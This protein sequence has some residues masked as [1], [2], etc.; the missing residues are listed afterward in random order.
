MGK[1]WVS[2]F[3]LFLVATL[4]NVYGVSESAGAQK[5]EKKSL[6]DEYAP[7]LYMH[8]DE[9][10]YPIKTKVMVENSELYEKNSNTL[11]DKHPTLAKLIENYNDDT[12]YLKLKDNWDLGKDQDYWKHFKCVVYGHQ[13]AENDKIVL[14]YWFFYI[15]NDWDNSHDG[16]WE[17]IQ[18]I[19]DKDENPEKITYSI[20]LGGATREWDDVQKLYGNHPAVFITIGAHSSWYKEGDNVWNQIYPIFGCLKCIDKTSS[21]GDVLYPQSVKNLSGDVQKYA[22]ID[23]SDSEDEHSPNNWI[24]WKGYWGKQVGGGSQKPLQLGN[25]VRILSSFVASSGPESPPFIDYFKVGNGKSSNGR[26]FKPLAWA[27]NP[28]PSNYTIC[29]SA[30]AQVSIRSQKPGVLHAVPYCSFGGTGCGS[31]PTIATL[32]AE[33]DLIFDVH[34]LDGKAV[35]LKISRNTST[36]EFYHVEFDRLNIPKHG[37]ASFHF[38]IEQNPTFEIGID[39]NRDGFSESYRL[40]DSLEVK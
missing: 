13:T 34:S 14:Q 39:K 9:R 10:F 17:M 38:S 4:L 2:V 36:G 24:H 3:F 27:N 6:L 25:N 7:I 29:A 32:S 12:Y 5:P 16:D 35:D 23:V 15:Y 1:T 21:Q 37:N 28:N 19:L 18:I 22:L 30:N 8:P 40:P 11:V 20:H 26:W 31:C 33:E